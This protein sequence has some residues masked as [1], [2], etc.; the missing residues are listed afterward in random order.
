MTELY[1]D[2][3]S[4]Q[5]L[6]LYWNHFINLL[7][8][9]LDEDEIEAWV[10]KLYLQQFLN[11]QIVIGG[12][13]L[14]FCNWIRDHHRN[15]VR[16][17][18]LEAFQAENLEEDFQLILR[19]QKQVQPDK[20]QVFNSFEKTGLDKKHRFEYFVNG[21]NSGIAYA[22]A[23]A[24]GDDLNKTHYNPLFLCGGVGLGKTHLMQAI[25]IKALEK[26]PDKNILYTSSE[27]FTNEVINGIRFG[28]ID[29]VRKK[30]RSLDLLLIDDIQFLENKNS[31][32]EEFF[33]TFNDLIQN[34]KQIAMTADRYP[35][36]IKNIEERLLNRF[37]SGM[38]ARV[39]PPDFETRMA[40]IHN[41]LERMGL[42]ISPE[43][44]SY[45]ASSVKSNV[46]DLKGVL[47]RFE[48]EWS[49][50]GQEITEERAKLILKEVLNLEHNPKNIEDIIKCV[51]S[52]FDVKIS[53]IKS[54]KRDREISTARQIAMYIAREITDLSYPVIGKHFGGK[55]HTTVLSACKKTKSLVEKSP[56][57]KQTI[58]A[59]IRE[60]SI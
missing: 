24:V 8:K 28:K 29:Q 58:Q 9:D 48:A 11:N 1:Q 32:Q 7:K 36:E 47:I 56:E 38:V 42:S 22:A 33:H 35:R 27:Q 17:S 54:N 49:L 25:G 60:L 31:T 55:N 5:D 23:A 46:R 52:T 13:N 16:S 12:L 41:E 59:M 6:S 34:Q 2:T 44:I 26:A 51:C 18:L 14:F 39:E 4:E 19:D 21:S 3:P 15:L 37:S 30:Y 43:V 20:S 57:I 53:D 45:V 10:N 50:L 40:I